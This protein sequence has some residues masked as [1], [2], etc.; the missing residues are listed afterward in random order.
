MAKR[1]GKGKGFYARDRDR[2]ILEELAKR[3]TRGLADQFEVVVREACQRRNLD[4]DSL[5]S[6]KHRK[7]ATA[8]AP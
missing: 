7:P 3:E 2:L 4:P 1:N 6:S 8:Q 5:L